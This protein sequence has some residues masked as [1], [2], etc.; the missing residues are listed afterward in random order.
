MGG[1]VGRWVGRLVGRS[2]GRSGRSGRSV[3]SVGGS[4]GSTYTH[5]EPKTSEVSGFDITVGIFGPQKE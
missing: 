4:V 1:W 5:E 3:R 2:V